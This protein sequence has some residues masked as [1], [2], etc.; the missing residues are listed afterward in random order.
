MFA[1]S[2]GRHGYRCRNVL[3]R[4]D[5]GLL[6]G[7]DP[8]L[9]VVVDLLQRVAFLGRLFRRLLPKNAPGYSPATSNPSP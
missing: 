4:L 2:A 3:P 6:I 1:K 7:L 9:V 8:R 5:L